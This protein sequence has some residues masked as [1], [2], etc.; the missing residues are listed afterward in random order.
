MIQIERIRNH[1]AQVI[2]PVFEYQGNSVTVYWDQSVIN[3]LD[4]QGLL[5]KLNNFDLQ[6]SFPH[7]VWE[8]S[9]EPPKTLNNVAIASIVFSK[10]GSFV[11]EGT[12]EVTCIL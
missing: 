3:F 9:E 11:E 10:R 6:I 8:I 4:K 1:K 5:G 2:Y 7:K 12:N